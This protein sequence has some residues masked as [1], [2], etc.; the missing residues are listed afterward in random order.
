MPFILQIHR[1]DKLHTFRL[2]MVSLYIDYCTESNEVLLL[3]FKNTKN[4]SR[5]K[6]A[7]NTL[8]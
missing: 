6:S 2:T 5:A 7:F 1:R 3:G 4:I 8:N